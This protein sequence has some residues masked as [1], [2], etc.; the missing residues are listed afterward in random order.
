MEELY[1]FV[2]GA[3][4]I[5]LDGDV[6]DVKAGS[7]IRVGQD[8]WRTWRSLPS[9]PRPAALALHTRRR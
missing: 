6:I 7:V 3:G 1:V 2:A 5:G 9:S 4:Q 8:V